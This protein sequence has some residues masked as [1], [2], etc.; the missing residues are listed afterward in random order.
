M[1]R[2]Y[3]GDLRGR[4]L[5]ACDAG[6][7]PNAAAARFRVARASV[8]GWLKQ[9]RDEGRSTPKRMGGG[10][11]PVIRGEVEA[12]LGRLLAADNDLTLAE[13]ADR[14]ADETGVRVHPWTVGRALRRLRQTRKKEE[15]ARERAGPR[16]GRGGAAG[17]AG[18][19]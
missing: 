3:S 19:A 12:A 14:L 13:Y 1:P 9:R 5:A 15:L 7:R 2:A 10:P 17:L 11:E 4:V 6:E 18:R 8:Y 16:R